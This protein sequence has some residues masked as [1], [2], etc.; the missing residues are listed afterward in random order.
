MIIFNFVLGTKS[1]EVIVTCGDNEQCSK[2][3]FQREITKQSIF[4]VRIWDHGI[5]C[6]LNKIGI[7]LIKVNRNVRISSKGHCQ[8]LLKFRM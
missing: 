1:S 6:G 3:K 5:F 7:F 4:V 2:L 8:I